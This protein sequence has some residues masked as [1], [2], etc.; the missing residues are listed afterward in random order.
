VCGPDS[1]DAVAGYLGFVQDLAADAHAAGA[2]PLEAARQADLGPYADLLD[3]ER[4]VGNLH[5]AY[6]EL[7]GGAPG[8]PIDVVAAFA[9]MVAYNGGRPLRCLA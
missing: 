4:I 5:R 9:D 7:D 1:I 2:S 8:E 3:A 6:A